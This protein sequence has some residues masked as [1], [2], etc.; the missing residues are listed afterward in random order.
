[1][2]VLLRTR[3]LS[4]THAFAD[5]VSLGGT[6]SYRGEGTRRGHAKDAAANAYMVANG[7]L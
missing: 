5:P 3:L 1:M 6:S 7:L 2:V 4:P